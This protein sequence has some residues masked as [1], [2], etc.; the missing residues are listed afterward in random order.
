[1]SAPTSVVRWNSPTSTIRSVHRST[2]TPCARPGR[3]A[4][5]QAGYNWQFGQA[6]VGLEADASWAD[7]FG[8]DT[9]FA[10][11]GFY[12]SGNCRAERRALGTLAARFG[13]LDR[14][15]CAARCIYGKAGA[16]GGTTKST[17]RPTAA[18]I[19]DHGRERHPAGAGRSAPVPSERCRSAGRSRPSTT[20][21]RSASD[22]FAT[23]PSGFQSV[24]SPDPLTSRR[25]RRRATDFSQDAHLVEGRPQL[26]ARRGASGARRL[27]R[28]G[29]SRSSP[30]PER[31]LEIGARYV[32]GWGRFQKDLG[33]PGEGL[34]RLPRGSP[35]AA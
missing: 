25:S 27:E 1:M 22:G 15:R 11:S 5:G 26:S 3:I 29:A 9:C 8:T 28:V 4:G 14:V 34:A 7:L 24:P 6:L 21:C 13:W 35:T 33:I 19:S 31:T 2:A 17:P 23:P 18:R 32:Y 16:L 20:T 10:Y 30:S 12:V